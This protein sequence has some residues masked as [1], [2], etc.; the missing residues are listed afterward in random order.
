ML[1]SLS[2]AKVGVRKISWS[3]IGFAFCIFLLS[4]HFLPSDDYD[5]SRHIERYD[6]IASNPFG[7]WDYFISGEQKDFLFYLL[8]YCG[9]ALGLSSGFFISFV[10]AVT[11]FILT[12]VFS[13]FLVGKRNRLLWLI[14]VL[15]FSYISLFSGVRYYFALSL[16]SIFVYFFWK[17]RLI[18]AVVFLALSAA[19]HFSFL[20]FFISFGLRLYPRVV[21]PLFSVGV[22]AALL[23]FAG[24]FDVD[25]LASGLGFLSSGDSI[26]E[27][28]KAYS[29]LR[30][31]AHRN[32]SFYILNFWIFLPVCFYAF[33]SKGEDGL[34]VLL[35]SLLI[36][37]LFYVNNYP[38][39]ARYFL[40]LLFLM[41]CSVAIRKRFPFRERYILMMGVAAL[42]RFLIEFHDHFDV[43]VNSY[44]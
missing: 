22:L 10:N 36:V 6:S 23:S 24:V 18:L 17:D 41:S 27:A 32:L 19:T 2:I 25:S 13:L 39:F 43:Y 3:N 35:V 26:G 1:F 38:V 15:S 33:R 5:R 30:G 7:F 20:I 9:D 16:F 12:S 29:E 11:A 4:W 40:P 28:S 21:L 34:S 37:M 44:F 42:I 8:M 14:F 31:A